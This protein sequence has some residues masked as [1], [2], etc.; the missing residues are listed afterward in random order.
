MIRP[1]RLREGSRVALI[2]PA[3]PIAPERVD[4]ALDR[5]SRLGL[6]PVLGQACRNSHAGYLA[7]TDADRLAD[8]RRA[9]DDP[10]IDAIWALRGGYGSMRLLA[11][12]DLSAFAAA[13]RPYI[14]FSDNTAVHLAMLARGVVSFHG[15]HAGGDSTAMSEACLRRVLWHAEPAGELPAAERTP[16]TLRAGTAEGPLVGGNL[17]LLASM[18]G[19]PAALSAR[20]RILFIEEV[21]ERPYRIDRAWTQLRLS[22][23][24]D[25][26]AG[27][28][29]GRF[30]DCDDGVLE[31]LEH[32]TA[33]LD[34]PVLAELPIG[35]EPDNWTLPMGVQARL[36]A[37]AGTL[38][39]LEPAVA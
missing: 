21:D 3:G 22:G 30:T 1:S 26:V 13:P 27:I 12:L 2:A 24:L 36:D 20:G 14:G 38:T 35:H 34:V 23:A 31:L 25:G 9:L 6:E 37:A 10:E 8:F 7:G 39:I 5:C 19:T 18:A 16:V 17:S 28:A 11:A 29:L 15:P 33:D 32:L 4:I